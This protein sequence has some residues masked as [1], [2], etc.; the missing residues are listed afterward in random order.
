ME[1]N[2]GPT[3]QR[4]FCG[5]RQAQEIRLGSIGIVKDSLE[6]YRSV[7]RLCDGP[8][9]F[10]TQMTRLTSD[11]I[12][13]TIATTHA[14]QRARLSRTHPPSGTGHQRGRRPPAMSSELE[15]FLRSH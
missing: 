15:L 11:R 13:P 1:G 6:G 8:D 2:A 4:E 9:H 3:F 7:P 12:L 5:A 14:A 10:R